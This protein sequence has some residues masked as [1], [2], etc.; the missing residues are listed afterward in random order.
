[1]KYVVN[2]RQVP[3]EVFIA[4]SAKKKNLGVCD[5]EK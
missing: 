4:N 3:M 5:V 2:Y 1:M